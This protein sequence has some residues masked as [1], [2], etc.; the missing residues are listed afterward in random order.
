[1]QTETIRLSEDELDKVQKEFLNAIRSV[2][3]SLVEDLIS[4]S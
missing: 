3:F 4:K 2:N 1:M